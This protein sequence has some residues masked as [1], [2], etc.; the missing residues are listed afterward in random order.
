MRSYKKMSYWILKQGPGP[1]FD[2]WYDVLLQDLVKS[3][4]S[5]IGSLNYHSIWNLTGTSAAVLLRC[6][7]YFRAIAQFQIQI[8]QLR[9]L[10]D[11]TIRRHWKLS[12][13]PD[14]MCMLQEV[15]KYVQ[16]N[17]PLRFN[18][19]WSIC[20]CNDPRPYFEGL[21]PGYWTSFS[22]DGREQHQSRCIGSRPPSAQSCSHHGHYSK[23]RHLIYQ[24][25]RGAWEQ[26]SQH[27]MW[28]KPIVRHHL[29]NKQKTVNGWER[30]RAPQ[31][32]QLQ[33]A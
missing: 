26:S 27:P 33:V 3:Q 7:S 12:Q 25:F 11:L 17:I 14:S 4:S 21:T 15:A 9:G 22:N 23:L 28:H 1:R 24:A 8:S 13:G 16:I 10:W 31:M 6:L 20:E 19:R 5:K 2:I 30:L 18:L 32:V 29:C